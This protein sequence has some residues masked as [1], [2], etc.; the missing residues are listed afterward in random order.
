MTEIRPQWIYSDGR[1][2]GGMALSIDAAGQITSITESASPP[3]SDFRDIA[4]FP[5][6]VNSH[7]HAFQW[8]LR[9]LV[10]R[11][12]EDGHFF[13]WREQ[14]FGLVEQL[15]EQL[16]FDLSVSAFRAMRS[17]GYTSVG[18]FHYLHHLP[19]GRPYQE[20]SALAQAVISAAQHVG[21]RICLLHGAYFRNSGVDDARAPGQARLC[22]RNV[23]EYLLRH[24]HL[25]GHI[26]ALADSRVSLGAALHSTRT[27]P[28]AD[29]RTIA[30]RWDGPLHIHI[31][32]QPREIEESLEEYGLRPLQVIDSAGALQARTT[33]VHMTHGTD[34]ELLVAAERG[35]AICFCPTTER[36]LGDGIGPSYQALAQRIP[37]CIG[38]DSH[39]NID[40]M[41][42]CRL[43]EG[44]ERLRRGSRNVIPAGDHRTVAGRLLDIGSTGG[45]NS[46]AL[47]TGSLEAGLAA[48]MIEIDLSDPDFA[49][50]ALEF[51]P[52]VLL[53]SGTTR[54]IRATWVAG[55]RLEVG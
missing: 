33:L 4:L 22:D 36:D 35:A 8:G 53:F 47:E 42:E 21:I 43:L 12:R 54:A 20:P 11:A 38:S 3:Q 15:D 52:D 46:L 5:G 29:I 44:H 18:E 41:V 17:A 40:P 30:K 6:F 1:L 23:D 7:S 2:R 16:L 28:A 48:D 19:G 49:G 39:A 25:A 26:G 37:L 32:E 51:V 14:M 27:V 55:Q 45:A 9:G 13:S 34:E 10:Q 50:V 24:S 31:N